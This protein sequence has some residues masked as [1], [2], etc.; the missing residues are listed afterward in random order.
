[1][2]VRRKVDDC[3]RLVP[4]QQAANQTRIGNVPV[5][6]LVARVS[7]QSRQVAQAPRIGQLVQIDHVLPS[8]RQPVKDEMG[9][10][11]AARQ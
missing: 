2:R 4:L 10:D 8:G 9:T 6:K 7:V 5:H 1:M 3:P 11:E